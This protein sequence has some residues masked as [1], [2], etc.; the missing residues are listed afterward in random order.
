[1]GT[2][3]LM[4]ISSDNLSRQ[5]VNG[6]PECVPP[7]FEFFWREVAKISLNA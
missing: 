2:H 3:D 7:F 1:M 6:V 5:L 4:H